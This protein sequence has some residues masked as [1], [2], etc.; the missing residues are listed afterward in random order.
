[1]LNIFNNE[2]VTESS[3]AAVL[4]CENIKKSRL[5]VGDKLPS[6]RQIEK[7]TKFQRETVRRAL[8]ALASKGIVEMRRGS[9]TYLRV[10]LNESQE[11]HKILL[12]IPRNRKVMYTED[13]FHLLERN[14]KDSI[15][16]SLVRDIDSLK[17]HD[18]NGYLGVIAV[19]PD[20]NELA[21]LAAAT[22]DL[23]IVCLSRYTNRLPVSAVIEDGFG[24]SYDLTS[25][26]IRNGN[27]RV[28]FLGLAKHR[29]DDFMISRYHGWQA[30][31]E[32]AGL[33][34]KD[35][36]VCW[37]DSGTEPLFGSLIPF[38]KEINYDS[39]LCSMGVILPEILRHLMLRDIDILERKAVACID[40]NADCASVGYASHNI[41]LMIETAVKLLEDDGPEIKPSLKRIAMDIHMV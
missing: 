31:L 17:E 34:V 18:L 2:P 41:K 30:A 33:N 29:S 25:W 14:P 9:G 20:K 38:F 21:L 24:A 40:M 8:E 36:P 19:V 35:C 4:L 26:L 37:V 16:F 27:E 12:W 15:Q 39:I 1:M 28:A 6:I 32:V 3:K 5:S 11:T 13:L 22:G 7:D 10:T 23:P